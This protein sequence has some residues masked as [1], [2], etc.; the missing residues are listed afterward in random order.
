M[1]RP[2][3]RYPTE[4]EL[5]ILKLLWDRGPLTVR[6]VRDALHRSGGGEP[7]YT[8]VM[9]VMNL[10]VDKRY[11]GRNKQGNG[12]VYQAQVKRSATTGQMLRD[13]VS[14]AFDGAAAS[15][16]LNLLEEADLD[17]GQ[18]EQLKQVVEAKIRETQ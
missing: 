12:Y 18:I 8:S 6:Q 3:S 13:L 1:A 16:A 2:P 9:T 10:M 5:E 4:R 7:A 11:L 17:A 14:R 15:V